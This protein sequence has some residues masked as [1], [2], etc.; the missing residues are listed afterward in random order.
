MCGEDEKNGEGQ[1]DEF[2]IGMDQFLRIKENGKFLLFKKCTNENSETYY[3]S[4][5]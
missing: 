3:E 1:Q 4:I 2:T 5:E